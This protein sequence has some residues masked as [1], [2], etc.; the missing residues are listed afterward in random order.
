VPPP[1]PLPESELRR[2]LFAAIARAVLAAGVP[3]LLI[4]DDVQWATC[5]RCA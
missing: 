4:A 1:E 5:S 2:R 3:L